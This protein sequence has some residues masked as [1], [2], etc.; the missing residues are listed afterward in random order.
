MNKRYDDDSNLYN[1]SKTCLKPKSATNHLSDSELLHNL[2]FHQIELEI[3][4]NELKK[5]Q[6][7]LETKLQNYQKFFDFA[8]IGILKLDTNACIHDVNQ[9]AVKILGRTRNELLDHQLYDYLN[10]DDFDILRL[11]LVNL[12]ASQSPQICEVRLKSHSNNMHWVYIL[13]NFICENEQSELVSFTVINDLPDIKNTQLELRTRRATYETLASATRDGIWDW[14]IATNTGYYTKRYREIIGYTDADSEFPHNFDLWVAMIHPDD[15]GHVRKALD[16]HIEYGAVYDVEF[17]YLHKSKDY[18]WCSARGQIVVDNNGKPI[19]ML[20]CVRDISEK[21]QAEEQLKDSTNKYR[22]LFENMVQGV[23]YQQAN[24]TLVDANKAALDIFGLAADE[25]NNRNSFDPRWKVIR[26]NGSRFSGE[27]HPSMQALKTGKPVVGVIAGV[28]NPRKEEYVW[29]CIDAIPQFRDGEQI[30][31]QVFVTMH[32]ITERK[33]IEEALN[34]SKARLEDA[35]HLAHIGNWEWN[36]DKQTLYW[37]DEIYQIFGLKQNE[38]TPSAEA[39]EAMIHPDD[40]EDFLRQRQAM[41]DD[42]KYTCI[43]HRIVLPN[44]EVRHVQERAQLI[45]NEQGDVPKV[46]GTVQDITERKQDHEALVR[47]EERFTLAMEAA[48]EG[49]YDWEVQTNQRYFSPHY[50]SMLG[51]HSKNCPKW[52]KLIHPDDSP[53]LFFLVDEYLSKRID[54]HSIEFRMQ[55]KSGEWLWMLNKGKIVSRGAHGEPLRI[56]GTQIDITQRKQVE[57]ALKES[58]MTARA[59]LN[60]PL[61]TIFL[62]DRN[63]IIVDLNS[64]SSMK[65]NKSNEIKKGTDVFQLF[66][67]GTVQTLKHKFNDVIETRKLVQFEDCHDGNWYEIVLN[68][69]FNEAGDIV[70]IAA[71]GHDFT[72]HKRN[73]EK[74]REYTEHLEK[75]VNERTQKI[76]QLEQ[77]RR[78]SEKLLATGRM[79]AGIAHEINNPLAGIKNSFMLIRKAVDKNHPNYEYFDLIDGEID[80]ISRIIRNM[81][82]IYA[83]KEKKE[84]L[85][86]VTKTIDDVIF[87]LEPKSRKHGV[88]LCFIAPKKNASLLLIE[89]YLKQT[90]FNLIQNAIEASP[91][92]ANV[93]VCL[94]N[95]RRNLTIQVI[96]H[97]CGI[98]KKQRSLIFE[99]FFTTKSA[100]EKMGMGLGLSV[101]KSMVEAMGGVITFKSVK[102]KGTQFTIKFEKNGSDE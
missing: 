73:E 81:Y 80:R 68:P 64:T 101:S 10:D 55:T 82:E 27:Q 69:I 6:L 89:D 46:L 18:R 76:Q 67:A 31:Y 43:D 32:D 77:K 1:S 79:A 87:L 28:F 12:F 62:L 100:G 54:S 39:F 78:E 90:L 61:D 85:V 94:R 20:G 58:E 98:G 21:K 24:G 2:K 91:A 74:I 7:Q 57:Q 65:F 22:T 3:Q 35:Q 96:D 47:S 71:F 56:V 8:P 95:N 5:S 70:K 49:L 88:K 9:T 99:P 11:H 41:L 52:R 13:S 48:D 36:S 97:G 102:N 42:K 66:P 86:N 63:G 38:F 17:R 92:D 59:L 34:E 37:S 51:Y 75:M 44:G 60:S 83:P 29:L 23:F 50:Y 40:R 16:E 53:R 72:E 30:P 26:E 19:R 15:R 93:T 84:N 33:H 14:D 25:L 45:F 4:N